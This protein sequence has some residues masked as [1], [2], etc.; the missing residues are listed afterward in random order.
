MLGLDERLREMDRHGVD[1][2]VLSFAPVGPSPNATL[3]ADL[4][5]TANEGLIA[6]CARHP[7]RFV[8]L[9]RVPLPDAEAAVA[10]LRRVASARCVRGVALL[11]EATRYR[12]D[13]LALDP[14]WAFA[15]ERNLAV[16]LHPPAGE[17]DLSGVFADFGLTSGLHAMVGS[18]AVLARLV[19]SGVPDR[20]PKLDVIATHL[21]GGAPFLAERL[22]Q[23][24]KG[25]AQPFS[26]YLRDRLYLDNCGFP[27]GPALRCAIDAAGAGR[28]VLGSDWPSR[29]IA[30]CLAPLAALPDGA[31]RAIEGG[32]AARWFTP[33]G[34]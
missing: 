7:D 5:R 30:E 11:A 27:A 18:A 34:R 12:P 19:Y 24:G 20:H 26:H 32:T 13:A 3:D 21:G 15:S 28:I 4:A 1:V 14:L 22:D 2:A 33:E 23:R 25:A 6:A 16:V 10:E 17:A 9:T 31:R 8:M 29:P